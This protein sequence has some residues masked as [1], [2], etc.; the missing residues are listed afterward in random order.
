[1]RFAVLSLILL[2]GFNSAMAAEK[3]VRKALIVSG[4]VQKAAAAKRSGIGSW[5]RSLFGGGP[6]VSKEMI[7][8]CL[9]SVCGPAKANISA[10]DAL[11]VR[12]DETV[13]FKQLWKNDVSPLIESLVEKETRVS[14]KAYERLEAVLAQDAKVDSNH[15]MKALAV[16]QTVNSSFLVP[17]ASEFA[18]LDPTTGAVKVNED[19]INAIVGIS[20]D[21][22]IQAA[23]RAIFDAVYRP[24]IEN[25]ATILSSPNP[26]AARLKVKFPKLSPAEALKVDGRELS[27]AVVKVQERLGKFLAALVFTTADFDL[28]KRAARGED[29]DQ[30]ESGFYYEAAEALE[31]FKL[32]MLEGK[33]RDVLMA[34]DV[35]VKSTLDAIKQQKLIETRKAAMSQ[36]GILKRQNEALKY[37]RP[38]LN[39][40][41]ASS[42]S[43]FA[44]RRFEK[45]LG[46]VKTAAKTVLPR[47]VSEKGEAQALATVDSA[48]FTLPGQP[49]VHERR[50]RGI[51][52]TEIANNIAQ[53]L[54]LERGGDE[55]DQALIWIAPILLSQGTGDA[56]TGN[57]DGT[58]GQAC[59][60]LPVMS[61]SDHAFTA[62]GKINL[63]WFSVTY[64]E[65]GVGIAS[66]ELGHVLSHAVRRLG[67]DGK[68]QPAFLE[69]LTCVASRNPYASMPAKFDFLSNTLFSEED[70]ADYFASQIQMTLEKTGPESAKYLRN[71]GCALVNDQGD[72]YEETG[73]APIPNDNHSSGPLRLILNSIDQ[74]RLTPECK[75]IVDIAYAGKPAPYCARP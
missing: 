38:R 36:K 37:C 5:L 52:S 29:F 13:A 73:L 57:V 14:L 4:N 51:L 65:V 54:E 59:R 64:P 55:I 69:S 31:N 43:D 9:V 75:S 35:D 41:L 21:E 6:E 66:H 33:V 30:I 10:Y 20:P 67:R 49:D 46:E 71:H 7:D 27:Q 45:M 40:L 42:T 28:F 72:E 53:L 58:V 3:P 60:S 34:V 16:F 2:L 22:K 12:R 39:A 23:V 1:M 15:P 70:W 74:G 50:L 56:T 48:V 62:Q 19:A 63:S 68:T 8:S 17:M 26:L 32:M 25:V 18:S 47:L 24:K 11:R 61:A 44:L